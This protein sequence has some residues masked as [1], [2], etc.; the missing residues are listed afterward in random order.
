MEYEHTPPQPVQGQETILLL[1]TPGMRRGPQSPL[2]RL[3]QQFEPFWRLCDPAPLIYADEDSYRSLLR[4][5]LLTSY[6]HYYCLPPESH[7][8]LVYACDI[9][10]SYALQDP[11]NITQPD[12][13]PMRVF[14]LIDP[15][16]PTS[17]YPETA[18]L[19]RDSVVAGKTFLATEA[20]VEEWLT[21]ELYARVALRGT[22]AARFWLD[23]QESSA[24]LRA[25]GSEPPRTN[26]A[27]VAHDKKKKHLLAFALQHFDLLQGRFG[28]RY[29]TGTTGDLLNGFVP[30]RS[31]DEPELESLRQQLASKL[32]GDEWV[33]SQP[34]GPRGGDTRIARRILDRQCHSV[35]FFEDPHY[36]REHEADIQL[37]E[38]TSRISD[39]RVLCIHDRRSAETWAHNWEACIRGGIP[40]PMTLSQAYRQR[41]GVEL[42]LAGLQQ[43]EG[44]ATGETEDAIWHT[45]LDAAAFYVLAGISSLAQE[46][47]VGGASVRVG[48]PWGVV[49]HELIQKLEGLEDSL[50]QLDEK[51]VQ[52]L[53]DF[54]GG[55]GAELEQ[56]KRWPPRLTEAL[57]AEDFL[58][59]GNVLAVPVVGVMGAYDRRVEANANAARLAKVVGGTHVT[60]SDYAFYKDGGDD[61]GKGALEQEWRDLDVLIL[62]GDEAKPRL[63]SKVHADLPEELWESVRGAVGECAGLYLGPDGEPW[64]TGQFRRQGIS[65]LAMRE[66]AARGGSI[67]IAGAQPRRVPVVEAMLAGGLVSTFITDLQFAWA[68]LWRGIGMGAGKGGES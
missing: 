45:I 18:T 62:T 16:D 38:R 44:H 50:C 19:Q 48:V 25:V 20:G 36:A 2:H 33:V 47:R 40:A 7:G 31:L 39:L 64:P 10:I 57:A 34:S 23:R 54:H 66:V 59:P 4:G 14:Y 65:H 53:S 15:S 35:L 17:I 26:I 46:R 63:G 68:I 22:T 21:L 55:S 52:R 6:P 12:P 58:R 11:D 24:L 28:A 29:A 61:S 13:H 9:V 27:M 32:N 67:L 49:L 43:E 41:F 3:V 42:V 60:L 51:T 37:L 8:A 1:T 56:V 5:G 30:Q